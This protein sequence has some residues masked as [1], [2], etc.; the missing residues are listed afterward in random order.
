MDL[1]G[2]VGTLTSSRRHGFDQTPKTSAHAAIPSSRR[3]TGPPARAHGHADVRM[4]DTTMIRGVSA[5]ETWSSG[6][7]GP[8]TLQEEC[9]AFASV[10]EVQGRVGR[11]RVEY[12]STRPDQSLDLDSQPTGSGSD[13]STQ[14]GLRLPPSLTSYPPARPSPS[15]LSV[16][17][18]RSATTTVS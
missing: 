9:P 17:G 14:L 6:L 16:T 15:R 11:V 12:N 4:F 18:S 13:P 3:V 10:A 5:V 1:A 2:G 8:Q 7:S